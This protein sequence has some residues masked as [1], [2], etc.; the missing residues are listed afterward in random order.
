MESAGDAQILS[1]SSPQCSC[2]ACLHDSL[3]GISSEMDQN[4]SLTKCLSLVGRFQRRQCLFEA[5]ALVR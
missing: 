2:A 5:L 3:L 4:P 1:S